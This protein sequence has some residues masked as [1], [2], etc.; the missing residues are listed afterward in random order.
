MQ[1]LAQQ[2]RRAAPLDRLSWDHLRLLLVLA[3]SGSFRSAALVAGVSLNTLRTKIDRLECQIGGQLIER[4][5]EGVRLTQDGS[6]LV[7][8]AREMRALG[9]TAERVQIGAAAVRDTQIK[10]AVTE[11]L[12]TFWLVPRVVAFREENADIQI[13]LRCE[14]TTP[15]VLFRDVDIAVQLVK[16]TNPNLIVQRVGTLHIMPF[17]ADSYLRANGTPVSVEDAQRH[18]LVWLDGDQ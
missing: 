4:S 9:K 17:A 16:P 12:G 8:I 5:V 1:V 14:M 18:T 10:I 6:E 2:P 13:N 15:D 11:G 3:E 7:S